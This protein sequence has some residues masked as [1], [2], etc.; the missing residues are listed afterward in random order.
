[1]EHQ[2]PPEDDVA[3]QPELGRSRVPGDLP[4]DEGFGPPLGFVVLRIREQANTPSR[5]HWSVEGSSR[6]PGTPSILALRRWADRLGWRGVVHP[7]HVI[8]RFEQQ[9]VD[10]R[11]DPTGDV[12]HQR[13]W[14]AEPVAKSNRGCE[15]AEA[16]RIR[17]R[18]P[19]S[20]PA[21]SRPTVWRSF[22]V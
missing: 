11:A 13:T 8:A 18:R 2:P 22:L 10:E 19:A 4:G 6:S 5:A 3:G 21:A 15:A 20:V 17:S 1:L 9:L 16:A 7:H 12:V 14:A